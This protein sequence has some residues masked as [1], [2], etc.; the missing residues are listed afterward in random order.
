M[1]GCGSKQAAENGDG[2]APPEKAPP[3]ATQTQQPQSQS[4]TQTN[5]DS[6]TTTSTDK[7]ENQTANEA[8]SSSTTTAS[9]QGTSS[10]TATVATVAAAATVAAIAVAVVVA[11]SNETTPAT[12]TNTTAASTTTTAGGANPNEYVFDA[13]GG[14]LEKPQQPKQAQWADNLDTHATNKS[15]P[16]TIATSDDTIVESTA[17]E[18]LDM[19]D[20][21]VETVDET[22]TPVSASSLK[23]QLHRQPNY[24]SYEA[25]VHLQHANWH[26]A[27]IFLISSHLISS[28][29][30]S[31]L[32]FSSVA[33]LFGLVTRID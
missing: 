6:T 28:H 17:I 12:T 20:I 10:T 26:P 11:S 15:H 4:Q 5:N 25:M 27:P 8:N 24:I 21:G 2:G 9:D 7:K 30:I 14:V 16:S 13:E 32:L 29:L 22:V 18:A 31:S 3:S 1:G 33:C 19:N 23:Q